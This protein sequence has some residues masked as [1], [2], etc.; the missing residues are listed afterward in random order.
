MGLYATWRF[1]TQCSGV[2]QLANG[3]KKNCKLYFRELGLAV[4]PN[5]TLLLLCSV[6]NKGKWCAWGVMLKNTKQPS[7]VKLE[8][9]AWG[10]CVCD[11]CPCG[12]ALRVEQRFTTSLW[13][14]TPWF[15]SNSKFIWNECNTV[16]THWPGETTDKERGSKPAT[17]P[18][19]S[20]SLCF[21][22]SFPVPV[23]YSLHPSLLK[24]EWVRWVVESLWAAPKRGKACK[25]C[26]ASRPSFSVKSYQRAPFFTSSKC[27]LHKSVKCLLCLDTCTSD[28][29]T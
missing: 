14:K 19:T 7:V 18:E 24:S 27:P 13:D 23:A 20:W 1:S 10:G 29:W 6:P 4:S 21:L 26:M 5:Y 28:Y 15:M 2:P 11:M 16:R 25:C 22:L 3:N 12:K 8:R 9:P 17:S